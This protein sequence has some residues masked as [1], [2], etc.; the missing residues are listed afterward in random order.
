MN[1][2]ALFAGVGGGILGGQLLGWKLVCA[3]ETDTYARSILLARQNEGTLAPFPIWDDVRTFNGYPW[4]G[5]VDVVSGGFPCQDISIAGK[6]AGIDGEH[7]GLWREMH[8]IIREVRPRYCFLENSPNLA[9]CGLGTVLG[10]LSTDRFDAEWITLGASDVDAPHRRKRIWILARNRDFTNSESIRYERDSTLGKSS[11][12]TKTISS[13]AH[14]DN[15]IGDGR[16][17]RRNH[18]VR[19]DRNLS[20][21]TGED[22]GEISDADG[23][24][25]GEMEQ[26]DGIRAKSQRANGKA[27]QRSVHRREPLWWEAEPSLGRMADG[28]PPVLDIHGTA[29]AGNVG[30]LATRDDPT[31]RH[32]IGK[33]RG[34]GNAQV[35]LCAAM[36]FLIL[37][38]RLNT[39]T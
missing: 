34:L 19:H 38:R 22:A 26:Y 17:T 39:F 10:D 11:E 28:I 5:I 14:V 21:T 12:V 16:D 29:A 25:C 3:V 13:S 37:K 30:R 35:P 23:V 9:N 7:S 27:M 18:H 20:R 24:R 33:I 32:R 2:L 6:L 36:A 1:E 31:A 4:R 15:A 8:R